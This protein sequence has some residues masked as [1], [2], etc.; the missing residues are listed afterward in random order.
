MRSVGRALSSEGGSRNTLSTAFPNPSP[1]LQT[2]R[3]PAAST[4][5]EQAP[6]RSLANVAA[7]AARS[8]SSAHPHA[9]LH[10]CPL[11]LARPRA[12][13]TPPKRETRHRLPSYPRSEGPWK[14]RDPNSAPRESTKAAASP[15]MYSGCSCSPVT[16]LPVQTYILHLYPLHGSQRSVCMLSLLSR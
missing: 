6:S 5:S 3:S 1:P 2:S 13:L 8:S 7:V 4:K 12:K 11:P 14:S 16:S 9:I 10:A 15:H